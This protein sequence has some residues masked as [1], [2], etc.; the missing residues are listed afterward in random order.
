MLRHVVSYVLKTF[1]FENTKESPKKHTLC[2]NSNLY[3]DVYI[4][5]FHYSFSKNRNGHMMIS[6]HMFLLSHML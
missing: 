4:L 3:L 1:F 2:Y 6:Y 5:E